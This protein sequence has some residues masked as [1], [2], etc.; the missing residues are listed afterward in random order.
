MNKDSHVET[1]KDRP[2]FDWY[3]WNLKYWGTKWEAYDCYSKIGK[4]YITFVFSTAWSIPYPVIERLHV[5]GY[6][7]ELR[8]ADED[9]GNNCGILSYEYNG[10]TGDKE[11]FHTDADS[12]DHPE[13]FARRLWDRY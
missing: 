4:S 5:M 1:D 6:D 8:Y 10:T 12:L 3:E 13:Q 9:Y 2:W 11:F 7:F